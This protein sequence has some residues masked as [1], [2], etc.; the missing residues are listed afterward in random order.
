MTDQ[1]NQTQ[2]NQTQTDQSE[3]TNPAWWSHM[4]SLY[5]DGISHAFVLHGN[6][7]DYVENGSYLPLPTFLAARLNRHDILIQ[8]DPRGMR[9]PLAPHRETLVNLIKTNPTAPKTPLV[10]AIQNNDAYN[11]AMLSLRD[12]SALLDWLLT[13]PL[14]VSESVRGKQRARRLRGAV[15]FSMG[16][17]MLPDT[18]AGRT[19]ASVLA[20]FIQWA[21][22]FSVGEQH[23]LVLIAESL[24]GLHSELRRASARWEAVAVPL[25][26]QETRERY[27]AHHLAQ[28]DNQPALA[29][30]LTVRTVAQ[31][32]GGLSLMQV[33]D[34]LYRGMGAEL[35]TRLLITERKQTIIAQEFAD[36]L[37]VNDAR[38]DLTTVGGYAYLKDWLN[39]RVIAPWQAQSLR[40]GGLLMSGPPGT[41]KTQ[42]AEALAGSAGV[43]F[44]V[45]RL[46]KILGHFVGASERNLERALQAI[47][48]LAPCLLFIDELDQTVRRGESEG[49]GS[50]VDNRVFARLL[51]FLEDPARRGKVL[52]VAAT[53]RPDLLDAALRSRFD[54]TLPVLPPTAEDR[55]AIIAQMAQAA[56]VSVALEDEDIETRTTGWTGRNLRDFMAMV[57]ELHEDGLSPDDALLEALDLYRPSLRESAEMTM[58]AL[59]EITDLRLVPPE[60]RAAV[61]G[62]HAYAAGDESGTRQRRAQL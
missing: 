9:F 1:T 30:D 26:D 10:Q 27:I 4:A 29:D 34:V 53:N 2:T 17:L 25:P 50:Q 8:I 33:Q 56:G 37:Q 44:V 20:R 49:S 62:A 19:D 18:E 5:N 48:S 60:H 3:Q 16:D 61:A 40:V 35:L 54:R 41:G 11:P 36:V 6:V 21:M 55:V 47:L 39:Q 31:M 12:T 57:A 38:F 51:E 46:S 7:R 23:V 13:T 42:M 32:T 45:F 22:S 59:R 52:V 15:I 24:V 28:H 14:T 58:L 43:P